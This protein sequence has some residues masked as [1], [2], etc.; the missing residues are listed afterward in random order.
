MQ[1]MTLANGGKIIE[2]KVPKYQ[3]VFEK[4]SSLHLENTTTLQFDRVKIT[5]FQFLSVKSIR[6]SRMSYYV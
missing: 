5:W 6:K 1:L 2:L 4:R 3:K